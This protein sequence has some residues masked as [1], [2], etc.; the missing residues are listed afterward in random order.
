MAIPRALKLKKNKKPAAKPAGEAGATSQAPAKPSGGAAAPPQQAAAAA[1]AADGAAPAAGATEPSAAAEGAEPA[2]EVAAEAAG[3]PRSSSFNFRRMRRP[4]A[5]SLG[6]QRKPSATGSTGGEL[7]AAGS[8]STLDLASMRRK[9]SGGEANA[10][11]EGLQSSPSVRTTSSRGPISRF[12][13]MRHAS[14][15]SEAI[16]V[17]AVPDQYKDQVA[18]EPETPSKMRSFRRKST[19]SKKGKAC[20]LYTSPSPRD[21]G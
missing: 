15:S 3:T 18:T 17:P 13:N 20:L 12:F 16:P 14:K 11:V 8:T 4:S 7:P 6:K 10:S 5:M 2:E 19:K 21:R 1:P 9:A